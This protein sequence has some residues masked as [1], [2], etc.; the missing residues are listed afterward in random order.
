MT[1]NVSGAEGK[2][3][4]KLLIWQYMYSIGYSVSVN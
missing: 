1:V 4:S 3:S 2:V